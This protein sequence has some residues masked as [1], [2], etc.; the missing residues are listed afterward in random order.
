[1]SAFLLS[2]VQLVLIM[3]VLF[4][5]ICKGKGEFY[6]ILDIFVAFFVLGHVSFCI[7]FYT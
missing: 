2:L 5:C 6:L 4:Y 1:M 7:V 3:Y